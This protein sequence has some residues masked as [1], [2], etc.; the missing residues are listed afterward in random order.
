VKTTK[1]DLFLRRTHL[2]AYSSTSFIPSTLSSQHQ[3][4]RNIMRELIEHQRTSR[5]PPKG[6]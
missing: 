5:C 1:E 6:K 2:S 3:K 4:S